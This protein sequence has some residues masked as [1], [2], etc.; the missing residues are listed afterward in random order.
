MAQ[1]I[2]VSKRPLDQVV[3]S[4][5]VVFRKVLLSEE[6]SEWVDA[7]VAP[8]LRDLCLHMAWQDGLLSW[9]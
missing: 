7:R 6:H 5:L 2:E 9:E 1:G 8:L 4:D 3:E